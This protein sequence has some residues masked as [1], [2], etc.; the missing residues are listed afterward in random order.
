MRWR[1][2]KFVFIGTVLL[3]LLACTTSG[4]G[5]KPGKICVTNGTWVQSP[6]L[7]VTPGART[8]S[9]PRITTTGVHW[10]S[11]YTYI[12]D[13]GFSGPSGG[14]TMVTNLAQ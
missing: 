7:P 8:R 10:I 9:R 12:D 13:V 5:G 4:D 3:P 6:S 14:V 11:S 2:W 1:E